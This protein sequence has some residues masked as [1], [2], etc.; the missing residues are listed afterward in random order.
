MNRVGEIL[1]GKYE[2]ARLL[3]KG[4]MGEVFVAR[5]KLIGK[6]VAI[7]FL[8][9]DLSRED[10]AV[11]RFAQEARAAAAV[12]HRGIVDIYDIGTTSDGAPY[13]VMELLDGES[14]RTVLA[15]HRKLPI[16][17]AAAVVVELLS[18]LVAAHAKGVV[19]R[20]LKPD[21]VFV[22]RTDG[23]LAVKLL[24]FG[25]AKMTEGGGAHLTKSGLPLGTAQYMSPEQARG[26]R[27]LDARVDV[28][29]VGVILYEALTGRL[30][31]QGDNYNALIVQLL[32]GEA[33]TP[34]SIE[35]SIP[36]PLGAVVM[37]AMDKDRDRRFGTAAE[38]QAALRPF[39]GAVDSLELLARAGDTVPDPSAPTEAHVSPV[40]ATLAAVVVPSLR[41]ESA[42]GGP[43]RGRPL[44]SL[45]VAG[46]AVIGLFLSWNWLAS[47]PSASGGSGTRGP[48]RAAAPRESRTAED[49]GRGKAP[50]PPSLATIAVEGVPPGGRVFLDGARVPELPIRIAPRT[51]MIPLRVEADGYEPSS[52]MIL[53]DRDLTVRVSLTKI[54]EAA[55]AGSPRRPRVGTRPGPPGSKI[56]TDTREFDE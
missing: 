19:H 56:Q 47:R 40:A 23:P 48:T 15:R 3:G 35:P 12:G 29:S 18:A 37:R 31:F 21:N 17:V 4:G 33:P 9:G 38:L 52:Q 34:R 51:G 11:A 14:L 13:L 25:I 44:R 8:R 10:E 30:P 1:D 2:V 24:D 36:E 53:P 41:T 42:A 46:I 39:A 54:A 28:W 26:E 7:K 5:H 32:R 6:D 20:D 27:D 16:G 22:E 55:P 43:G 49:E 50:A 45:V